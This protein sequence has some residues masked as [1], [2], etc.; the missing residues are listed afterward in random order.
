[1]ARRAVGCRRGGGGDRGFQGPVHPP[2]VRF[3]GLRG[4]GAVAAQGPDEEAAA[5]LARAAY[6]AAAR[7]APGAA[8]ELAELAVARTPAGLAAVR[9]SRRLAAAEYLY[10]AGDTARARH[11][12]E[13][14]VADMPAGQERAAA[15]L[16]LGRILLHDAG[17]LAALPVLED[18]LA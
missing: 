4:G 16:V 3:G 18:A 15:R 5:A 11:G 7:G 10:R 9:R 1:M 14:V 8:A 13:A 2:A 17:E 12:L 6:A